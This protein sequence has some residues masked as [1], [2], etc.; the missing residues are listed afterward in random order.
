[1]YDCFEFKRFTIRQDHCG[2]KVGTDG[3]LLGA[4]ADGGR[5]ILDVGTGTGLI[6]LIM[7]QRFPDASVIGI[8]IDAEACKQADENVNMSE[9]NNRISIINTTFQD[10]VCKQIKDNEE[11]FDAIACNPPFFFD[12]GTSQ[13]NQR[14]IA[15]HTCTLPYKDLFKGVYRLLSHDGTF[16]AV[17]PF[18]YLDEFINEGYLCGMSCDAQVSIKTTTSKSAKRYLLSFGKKPA[19]TGKTE[20][21]CLTDAS[22]E[23]SAW[24]KQLTCDLYL[25]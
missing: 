24:Y 25:H 16:S 4:W 21:V 2:M 3:V 12:D 23:R 13:D 20:T 9:F 8:D 5:R 15:R 14:N 6:A 1:M 22:G 18:D 19:K 7:A 17:I 11:P 10:F